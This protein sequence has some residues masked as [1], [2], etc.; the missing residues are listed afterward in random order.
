MPVQ[1]RGAK[2]WLSTTPQ[3]CRDANQLLTI[4]PDGFQVDN[5]VLKNEMKGAVTSDSI[6]GVQLTSGPHHPPTPAIAATHII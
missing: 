6:S 2:A 1:G 3:H 4:Q 5:M